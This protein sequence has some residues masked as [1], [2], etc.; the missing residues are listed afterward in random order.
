MCRAAASGMC[1][2]FRVKVKRLNQVGGCVDLTE[3]CSAA[4][5][6]SLERRVVLARKYF[7]CTGACYCSHFQ[8][9]RVAEWCKHKLAKLNR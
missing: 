7:I 2:C 8:V 5:W 3:T 1:H 6:C 4:D 9:F